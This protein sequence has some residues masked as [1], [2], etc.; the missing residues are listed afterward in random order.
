MSRTFERPAFPLPQNLVRELLLLVLLASS[1]T[2][3]PSDSAVHSPPTTPVHRDLDALPALV[4]VHRVVRAVPCRGA[5][6]GAPIVEAVHVRGLHA[7]LVRGLEQRVEPPVPALRALEAVQNRGVLSAHFLVATSMRMMSCDMM[8][9]AAMFR[10]LRVSAQISDVRAHT[11]N[12]RV[13]YE[14]IEEAR[15]VGGEPWSALI[16]SMFGGHPRF[17]LSLGPW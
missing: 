16:L 15:P 11:T 6:H 3:F 1:T 14:A 8:L 5:R 17:P 10:G 7:L 4:A 13:A 9:P 2:P 12:F